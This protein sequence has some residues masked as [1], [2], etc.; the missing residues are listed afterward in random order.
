MRN[1]EIK[2]KVRQ[3]AKLIERAK[4]LSETTGEVIKQHDTFYSVAKG[5]LKLRKFE[6][7]DA[8]L[9][10]YERPDV[11]GPKLSSYEKAI[12]KSEGVQDLHKVLDRA[13]GS[14]GIV[15]KVRYLFMVGQTRVHIDS[16]ENLGDF[17]EL[18]VVLKPE[19]TPED[20]EKIALEL[21]E[22]LGV[23]KE[24]LMSGAYTDLLRQKEI[25]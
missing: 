17:M 9:I 25:H 13:L 21:M 23:E 20:G 4:A 2:A 22:D 14:T 19:Q 10:Y 15:K 6:S 24:D 5:R 1:I 7:G 16:V 3:L 11:E 12:I 8:E 18:E